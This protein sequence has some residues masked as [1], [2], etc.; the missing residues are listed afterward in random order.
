VDRAPQDG[1]VE[2]AVDD[3]ERTRREQREAEAWEAAR[4]D[5]AFAAEMGEVEASYRSADRETWPA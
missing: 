1:V 4:T 5:P 3:L 2:L